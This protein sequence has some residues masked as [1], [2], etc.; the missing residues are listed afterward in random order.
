MAETQAEKL[1][2]E[3]QRR[4][5]LNGKFESATDCARVAGKRG[6]YSLSR[7]L[8]LGSCRG[9]IPVESRARSTVNCCNQAL[10]LKT[11][12]EALYNAFPHSS[13]ELVSFIS[14]RLENFRLIPEFQLDFL[15]DDVDG[16]L[17]LVASGG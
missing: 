3:E 15:Q 14:C 7:S 2:I 8:V 4:P 6:N 5:K 11:H 9:L 17:R 13:K 1:A 10:S 16:I 12:N